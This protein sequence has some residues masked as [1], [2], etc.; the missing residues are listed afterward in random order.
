MKT[1][2]LLIQP[3]R[4]AQ[5]RDLPNEVLSNIAEYLPKR[6]LSRC[7]R[8]ASR[9][10]ALVP[11]LYRDL[12]NID[13]CDIHAMSSAA[14]EEHGQHIR[15]LKLD[16]TSQKNLD[17]LRSLLPECAKHLAGLTNIVIQYDDKMLTAS[18]ALSTSFAKALR[19]PEKVVSMV[20]RFQW[21]R[22]ALLTRTFSKVLSTFPNLRQLSLPSLEPWNVEILKHFQHLERLR[23]NDVAFVLPNVVK[24]VGSLPHLKR[25]HL[26]L[27]EWCGEYTACAFSSFPDTLEELSLSDCIEVDD[28]ATEWT[29]IEELD[30]EVEIQ[31]RD[32]FLF[33][34]VES[35]YSCL[36]KRIAVKRLFVSAHADACLWDLDSSNGLYNH[37]LGPYHLHAGSGKRLKDIGFSPRP[38]PHCKWVHD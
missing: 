19:H 21:R 22:G 9:F 2:G 7:I 33:E 28:D 36:R 4:T 14:L 12:R 13:V 3:Q 26:D 38:C 18:I 25:L 15:C 11:T 24:Y 6:S 29:G 10:S 37:T 20:V 8:T 17:H 16:F 34:D 31:F 27:L 30:D 1:P 23:L 35:I 5:L 32:M